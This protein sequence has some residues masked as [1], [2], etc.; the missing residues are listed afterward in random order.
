MCKRRFP[1]THR[2]AVE[3]TSKH[4]GSL[5][6]TSASFSVTLFYILD[7]CESV[8][9]A[10]ASLR[11]LFRY[12]LWQTD[13]SATTGQDIFSARSHAATVARPPRS[14]RRRYA[15][16]GAVSTALALLCIDTTVATTRPRTRW[17]QTEKS[18]LRQFR[19]PKVLQ[20]SP[21]PSATGRG[22]CLLSAIC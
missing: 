1:G 7:G 16:V 18:V 4:R 6:P 21:R 13:L 8:V 19:R 12:L 10:L 22:E 14:T 9:G 20:K 2:T 11:E 3:M 17:E 5:I 15:L